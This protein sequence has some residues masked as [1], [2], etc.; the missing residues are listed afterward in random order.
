MP[1]FLRA[2][3]LA[4]ETLCSRAAQYS[5]LRQL[6]RSLAPI[7]I[8]TR[9]NLYRLRALYLINDFRDALPFQINHGASTGGNV[10]VGSG[11]SDTTRSQDLVLTWTHSFARGWINEFRAS[12]NRNALLQA[13]PTDHTTPAQLG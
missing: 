5:I 4:L 1:H 9:E 7:Q 8:R 6:P 3:I 12:A 13:S 10:P 11:I 2:R